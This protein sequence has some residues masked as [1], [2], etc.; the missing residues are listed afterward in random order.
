MRLLTIVFFMFSL[1]A[2]AALILDQ[3]FDSSNIQTGA[4]FS[5]GSFGLFDDFVLADTYSID[6]ISFWGGY[7]SSGAQPAT[8]NFRVQI[9]SSTSVADIVYD[10]LINPVG[11]FD[12]GYNHNGSSNGD[13]LRFDVVFNDLILG[14]GSYF[15]TFSSQNSPSGTSFY[16]QRLRGSGDRASGSLGG[17]LS[18]FTALNLALAIEGSQAQ[19]PPSVPE[20]ASIVLLGL[21]L[22][23]LAAR[24]RV[25]A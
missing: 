9:R 1:N 8:P 23:G 15:I 24:R 4:N 20:P 16:W 22:A 7:W 2:N 19:Q 10:S 21:G 18:T 14:A 25:K 17:E 6:S 13:I 11:V 12:T 3:S 5:Q